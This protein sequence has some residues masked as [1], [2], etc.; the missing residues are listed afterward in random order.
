MKTTALRA[1]FTADS[2]GTTNSA[3]GAS[4]WKIFADTP[5]STTPVHIP[6]TVGVV[7]EL[8]KTVEQVYSDGT[9]AQA[10]V[11]WPTVTKEQV[12]QPGR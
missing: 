9:R 5:V 12:S 8:P 1:T 7:P 11:T 10:P 4:E 6:T 2:N 3:V